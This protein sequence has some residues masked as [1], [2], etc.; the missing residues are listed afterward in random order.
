M[1]RAAHQANTQVLHHDAA[2][3]EAEQRELSNAGGDRD[4]NRSHKI[5]GRQ[6]DVTTR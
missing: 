1:R 3:P 6:I 5:V 2:T 4:P